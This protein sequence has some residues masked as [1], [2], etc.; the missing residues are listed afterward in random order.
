MK[1]RRSSHGGGGAPKKPRRPLRTLDQ[2]AHA[3]TP[4]ADH[5]VLQRLY[6]QVLTLRHYLLSQ[7]PTSAKS[8]RRRIAQLG[9]STAAENGAST[10]HLDAELG[11]L[12]DSALIGSFPGSST[13]SE[14]QAARERTRDID[15]FTQQRPQGNTGATFKPGYFLQSE[16]TS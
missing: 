6:P 8:R 11:Q 1:R 5:P 10:H 14:E 2:S 12:L 13:E 3:T 15:V 16:S 4:G 7:L 9:L